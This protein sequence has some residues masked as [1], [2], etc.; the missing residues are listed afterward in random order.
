MTCRKCKRVIPEGLLG[1]PECLALNSKREEARICR[2]VDQS[3]L[4]AFFDRVLRGAQPVWVDRCK[5]AD[6]TEIWHLSPNYRLDTINPA[7]CGVDCGG[8]ESQGGAMATVKPMRAGCGG[9]MYNPINLAD[10]RICPLCLDRLK[11]RGGGICEAVCFW[12]GY[13]DGRHRDDCRLYVPD[14]VRAGGE[15]QAR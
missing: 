7:F 1:C 11:N 14:A 3:I 4:P 12:C 2:D 10:P 8:P 15:E 5:S 13:T 9:V 6:G